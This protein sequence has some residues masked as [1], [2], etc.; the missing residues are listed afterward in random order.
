VPDGSLT[1]RVV[2]VTGAAGGIGAATARELV[3]RGAAVAL[4]DIDAARVSAL[5]AELGD[6][7]GAWTADI[8]DAA[9][10]ERAVE[11]ATARFGGVDAVIANAGIEIIAG[12]GEM[13]PSDFARVIDINLI[14]TWTTMRATLPA[15]ARRRGYYLLVASLSAVAHAPYN[16]AYDASKAGVVSLGRTLRLESRP[17]GVSVGIAY[18]N[19]VDT[20]AA[21]E[22]VE[23]PRVQAILARMPGG[24]PKPTPVD[25]VARAFATAIERR[26]ARVVVPR[27]GIA[28]VYLPELAQAVID[29]VLRKV[30]ADT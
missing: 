22:A 30:P 16:G 29:R 1:G 2:L 9:Q 7:V 19:Y 5:A 27:S 6:G 13:A 18:L 15:V 26:S 11:G 24:A 4:I 25:T 12:I 14:G 3:R 28:A 20:P 17:R 23:N 21:R 10:L 8:T